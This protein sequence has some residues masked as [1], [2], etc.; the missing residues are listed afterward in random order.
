MSESIFHLTPFIFGLVFGLGLSMI[1]KETS[2]TVSHYPKVDDT[3]VFKDMTETCYK[4]NSTE[5]NCD[6]NEA[7]LKPYPLQ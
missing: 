2:H 1:F 3:R 5:V 6:E 4:Y 7:T